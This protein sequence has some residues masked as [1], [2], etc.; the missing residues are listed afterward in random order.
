MRST[1]VAEDLSGIASDRKGSIPI[2]PGR[3]GCTQSGLVHHSPVH[4]QHPAVGRVVR[5]A[6]AK[7]VRRAVL[8]KYRVTKI[9]S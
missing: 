8:A 5:R 6:G 1:S 3:D 4:V 9:D 7:H 2:A